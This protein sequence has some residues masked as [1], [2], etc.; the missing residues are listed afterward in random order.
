MFHFTLGQIAA[1]ALTL[2]VCVAFRGATGLGRKATLVDV[3]VFTGVTVVTHAAVTA[4]FGPVT[5]LA[6]V[7]VVAAAITGAPRRLFRPAERGR[8][9]NSGPTALSRDAAHGGLSRSEQDAWD[10]LT[11]RLA[12]D[13]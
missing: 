6:A 9:R 11:A 12:A 10:D 4:A 13:A 1:A 5:G 2:V 7:L 8:S 3:L